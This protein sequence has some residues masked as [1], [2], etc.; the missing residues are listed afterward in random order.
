VLVDALN[1]GFYRLNGSYL[2][3]KYFDTSKVLNCAI[4]T[5]MCV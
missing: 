3:F 4:K 1:N 2:D 5:S